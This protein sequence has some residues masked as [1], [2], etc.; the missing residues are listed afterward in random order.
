MNLTSE[1]FRLGVNIICNDN[2]DLLIKLAKNCL[3]SSEE[4]VICIIETNPF[5]HSN[6]I[7]LSKNYDPIERSFEDVSFLISVIPLTVV[8]KF[9][10]DFN[11]K[12]ISDLINPA[13]PNGSVRYFYAGPKLLTGEIDSSGGLN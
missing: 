2:K 6:L 1:Q 3:N 12:H 7:N 4:K 10:N 11:L 5:P 9:F 13:P 8:I